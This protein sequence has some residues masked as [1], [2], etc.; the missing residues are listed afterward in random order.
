M[1]TSGKCNL[2]T[3]ME[4]IAVGEELAASV[5]FVLDADR[6]PTL[7]I[8]RV[9]GATG[10]EVFRTE[11]DASGSYRGAVLAVLDEL[12]KQWETNQTL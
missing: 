7:A 1:E 12:R 9:F 2:L 5:T 8:G 6:Q 11:C 4:N 10:M 3:A